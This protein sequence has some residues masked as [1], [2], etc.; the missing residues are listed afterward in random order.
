MS[1]VP[2]PPIP[3]SPQWTPGDDGFG[4]VILFVLWILFLIY[5]GC[6]S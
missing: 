5:V 4:Y 3:P 1:F 6:S 2:P